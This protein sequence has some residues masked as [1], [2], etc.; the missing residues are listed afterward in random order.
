MYVALNGN[1]VIS[2]INSRIDTKNLYPFK[3]FEGRSFEGRGGTPYITVWDKHGK[4][5]YVDF[6]PGLADNTYGVSIDTNDNVYL[7]S[8][9]TRIYNKKVYYHDQTGTLMKFPPKK[10]KIYSTNKRILLKMDQKNYLKR[11]FD[12]SNPSFGK[13][14]V[15]GS[16][17]MYGGVGWSGKNGGTCSCWNARFAMDYF[18]RSFAP[19][20]TRFSIAMI[21]SAGNLITRIGT[22]GNADAQGPNSKAPVGGDEVGLMY[23]A[24]LT[25]YTDKKLY[26]ADPGN[27]KIVSVTLGYHKEERLS[28]KKFKIKK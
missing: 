4:P 2:G 15:T 25:T 14:W 6:I 22:Y 23:G 1:I 16:E 28:L 17:W 18:N 9:G 12:I 10:G 3:T 24:Y 21:D 13:A 7:M 26:I 19:E 5:L 11:D 20:I 27:Q 8:P